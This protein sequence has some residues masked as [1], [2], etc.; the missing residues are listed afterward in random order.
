MP[1]EVQYTP[2][3][4]GT[5]GWNPTEVELPDDVATHPWV[6]DDFADGAIESPAQAA[7]R[8]TALVA[9]KDRN[10][11]DAARINAQAEQAMR[12]ATGNAV[13]RKASS[14]DM[15]KELNTPV[16]ELGAQQGKDIDSPPAEP[17]V[18]SDADLNT[19]VNVLQEQVAAEPVAPPVAEAPKYDRHN[20]SPQD[21]DVVPGPA[22]QPGRPTL[23]R[24]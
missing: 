16:N 8:V 10:A 7:A 17:L 19:P 9:E 12:R 11:E 3:R 24:K 1:T 21:S 2:Q 18:P 5:H 15:E 13:V 4:R 22:P 14:S 20:L 6:A 23:K